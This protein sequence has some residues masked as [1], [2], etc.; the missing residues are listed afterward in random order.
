MLFLGKRDFTA[1]NCTNVLGSSANTTAVEHRKTERT[2]QVELIKHT[3]AVHD[4]SITTYQQQRVYERH[5]MLRF[6]PFW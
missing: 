6:L 3:P 5:T 1:F 4:L 2:E